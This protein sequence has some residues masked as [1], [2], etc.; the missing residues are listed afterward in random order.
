MNIVDRV[1]KLL[2]SPTQEWGV[3]KTETHTVVGLY[4]HYVMILAAIPAVANFIG[5]S[6]VGYSGFGTMTYRIP[7]AAGVATMVLNYLLTLGSVYLLAL[8]ID[9]QAPNFGGERD[10][11]QALKVA[12]F[13]PT[14]AWLAGIFFILPALTILALVGALYSL[15]LLYTGLGQLMGVAEERSAGYVTIVVVAA[16]VLMVVIGAIAGLAMPSRSRGF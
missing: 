3:I 15:W 6:I 10:F 13:F 16:I 5:W 12:A 9:M 8:I 4:T 7:L 11:I 14:A 2:L 1:K